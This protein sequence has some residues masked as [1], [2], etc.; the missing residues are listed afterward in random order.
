MAKNVVDEYAGCAT[1]AFLKVPSRPCDSSPGAMAGVVF[2]FEPFRARSR[3]DISHAGARYGFTHGMR[4][5]APAWRFEFMSSTEAVESHF[6][7][8]QGA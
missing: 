6:V 2:D 3:R 4:T 7:V 5:D 1:S 8:E